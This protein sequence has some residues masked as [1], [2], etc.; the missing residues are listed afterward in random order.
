[1]KNP[2]SKTWQND[3][4]WQSWIEYQQSLQDDDEKNICYIEGTPMIM[5][6]FHSKKIRHTADGAKIVSSNDDK[7]FTFRGSIFKDASQACEI[8][9]E[10]SQK[11]A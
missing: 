11:D 5:A 8:G 2:Q 7:N 6:K 9:E 1:M 10:V 3:K 4:L